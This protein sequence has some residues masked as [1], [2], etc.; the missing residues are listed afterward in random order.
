M[1]KAR[2]PSNPEGYTLRQSSLDL[3]VI[4]YEKFSVG[5]SVYEGST[6]IRT[7]IL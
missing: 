7:A 3:T 5:S 1:D 2:K 4:E 6:T